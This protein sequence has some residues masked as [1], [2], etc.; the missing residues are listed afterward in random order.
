MQES[1][2]IQGHVSTAAYRVS[3]LLV[4]RDLPHGELSSLFYKQLKSRATCPEVSCSLPGEIPN[5]TV[6][7]GPDGNA[8]SYRGKIL[9]YE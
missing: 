9:R 4:L 5:Q 8:L 7:L 1:D 2:E 3:G 6:L